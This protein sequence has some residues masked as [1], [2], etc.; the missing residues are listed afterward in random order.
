MKK[1]KRIEKKVLAVQFENQNVKELAAIFGNHAEFT[2]N[3]WESKV[4]VKVND[5]K[6]VLES[7]LYIVKDEN[8][9]YVMTKEQF[10]S[11]Y[12]AESVD[13]T[14]VFTEL[15]KPLKEYTVD[16][17]K[18]FCK[19]RGISKYSRLKED[20]LISL[21]EAFIANQGAN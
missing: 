8:I 19:E 12:I 7:G 16:E 17:L 2:S 14:V 13:V 10:E 21:L 1:F 4:V 6:L 3:G 5:K 11:S 9:F 18:G 15:V 20:E